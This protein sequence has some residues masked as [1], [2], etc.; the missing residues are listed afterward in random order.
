MLIGS[1]CQDYPSEPCTCDDELT[2]E[3]QICQSSFLGV[4]EI[5]S[6]SQRCRS[7]HVCHSVR[8]TEVLKQS[9][10]TVV[11]VRTPNL[12][13][14]C[15][16]VFVPGQQY[17]LIGNP[18]RRQL[19]VMSCRYFADWSSLDWLEKQQHRLLFRNITC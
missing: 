16:I 1:T 3:E 6:A 12:P 9:S 18:E 11:R 7:D 17:L 4:V 19:E 15:G 13:M 10:A 8:V 14:S 5:L 2:A